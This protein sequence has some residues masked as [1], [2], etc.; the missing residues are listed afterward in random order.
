MKEKIGQKIKET[1][2]KL[3]LKQEEF[4]ELLGFGWNRQTVGDIENAKRD[5]K[6]FELAKIAQVLHSDISHFIEIEEIVEVQPYILWREKPIDHLKL[7]AFFIKKCRDF[8]LVEILNHIKLSDFRKLPN[9]EMNLKGS[10]YDFAYNLAEEIRTELNLGDY[11]SSC[12][13][14]VLEER[15]GIKFLFE[16]LEGKGSAATS[17]SDFG[18]SIIVN[19]A[20]PYWRQNYSIAHELFHLIT[21]D[22]VLFEQIQNDK[23]LHDKNEKMAESF[24]AGLLLPAESLKREI[25]LVTRDNVFQYSELVALARQFEVS[26]SAFV[27]R[28]VNIKLVTPEVAK[29]VLNDKT[30]LELDKKN[31]I[32][33]K[34]EYLLSRRFIRLA[35][36]SY[37]KGDISRSRLANMLT[38]PLGDLSMVLDQFG[39]TEMEDHEIA[40]S[41]S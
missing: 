1:R 21:W 11:P 38:V 39:L 4:A 30:L 37:I 26:L 32:N 5:V 31:K 3:G 7:E 6:A 36:M 18:Y 20:E 17:I 9:R 2:L 16:K 24:A 8:K 41:N 12:L 23:A 28:M 15:F 19:S 34:D 13:Q 22:Q 40:L 27:W 29:N 35:Y 10:G 33:V 25:R 14:K